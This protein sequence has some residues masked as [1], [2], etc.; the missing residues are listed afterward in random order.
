[1][2]RLEKLCLVLGWQ[3]GTIHQVNAELKSLLGFQIDV[4]RLND[5]YFEELYHDLSKLYLNRK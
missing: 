5:E 4:L 1:M 2:T 3:G